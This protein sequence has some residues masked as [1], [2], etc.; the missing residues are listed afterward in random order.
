MAD[1]VNLNQARK[2]KAKADDKARATENRVRFG[3]SKAEK[4]LEA[5][6]AEKLRRDLDGAK[7]ED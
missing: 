5:A 7:R 2:A 1:I 6:R 4:S 3:R